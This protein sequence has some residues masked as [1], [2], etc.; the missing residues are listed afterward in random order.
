M[1]I[2]PFVIGFIAGTF[3]GIALIIVIALAAVNK[4][5]K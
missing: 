2:P 1:Y 5:E 4:E 3:F